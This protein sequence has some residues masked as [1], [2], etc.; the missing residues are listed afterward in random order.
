MSKP[1]EKHY[2][3]MDVDLPRNERLLMTSDPGYCLGLWSAM[4]AY[5]REALSDGRVPKL[6]AS[7]LWSNQSNAS[8]LKEMVDVGLLEDAGSHYVVLKYAPRNQT[9]AM[10]NGD[11]EQAKLR[12]AAL[13]AKRL[14]NVQN[15]R[16]N[17]DRTITECSVPCSPSVL[18][19][20]PLPLS[21]DSLSSPAEPDCVKIAPSVPDDYDPFDPPEPVEAR[22]IALG[23]PGPL[24]DTSEDPEDVP[25][26]GSVPWVAEP[27]TSVH[28]RV[29]LQ[30]PLAIHPAEFRPS[31]A[32]TARS[33]DSGLFGQEGAYFA[34]GIRQ[35]QGRPCM[36]PDRFECRA[37]AGVAETFAPG[38]RG[39][40]LSRWFIDTA[41]EYARDTDSKFW[42][43]TVKRFGAW[44]SDGK[45]K[46]RDYEKKVAPSRVVQCVD[47]HADWY[48]NAIEQMG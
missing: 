42:G 20:L 28:S 43:R 5:A 19:P 6:Y 11:R 27:V 37:L 14:G 8:R 29:P 35:G 36:L 1:R 31:L 24:G 44:L 18:I 12:M 25:E 33:R 30:P 17:T 34:E 22:F 39:Q 15:V 38:L 23:A 26:L 4:T 41:A 48:L 3:C 46:A 32:T 47:P 7:G 9:K 40:E 45:P 10:V 21:S 13:R 2:I 16:P